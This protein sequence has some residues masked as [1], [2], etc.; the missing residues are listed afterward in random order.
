MPLAGPPWAWRGPATD[1]YEGNRIRL[2][3]V[4]E[5]GSHD[6]KP[7]IVAGV[8]RRGNPTIQRSLPGGFAAP[9]PAKAVLARG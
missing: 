8:D 7:W 2:R 5:K 3:S 4:T 6:F 9:K 1:D